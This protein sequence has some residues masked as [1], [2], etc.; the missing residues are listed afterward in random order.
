MTPIIDV[1]HLTVTLDDKQILHDINFSIQ[2]EETVAII[3]PNGAGKTTLF[4]ALLGLVP[5]E[6]KIT[7]KQGIKIGYVPQ[8]LY[9]GHDLPLTTQEFFSF[10]EK[11]QNEI[12]RVLSAV[13][14]DPHGSPGKKGILK[15]K[16]GVLSSGELQKVLIAWALLGHPNVLL[17]D[18][19][20]SGIDVSME[21]TIYSLLHTLQKEEKLTVILI[22]HELEIVYRFATN[23]I[24]L[25]KESVC[26]GSPKTVMDKK[27]LEKTF[28]S[29][30][31][32]YKHH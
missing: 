32:F 8:K 4:R 11:N 30:I 5:Y 7:W 19:P 3:G 10:K 27:N 25:N 9:V 12:S 14:L 21:S 6:G 20:T 23:V 13:G 28:G 31:A 15:Q 26:F 1:S 29:D 16:L 18:E 22:S 2:E 24:C 17:F